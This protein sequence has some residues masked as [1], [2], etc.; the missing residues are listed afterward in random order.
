MKKTIN[1]VS[2]EAF[3]RLLSQWPEA[4]FIASYDMTVLMLDENR[5]LIGPICLNKQDEEWGK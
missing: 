3:L 1:Y 5:K 4:K 2:K